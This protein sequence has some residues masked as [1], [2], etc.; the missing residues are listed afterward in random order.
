MPTVVN[1]GASLSIIKAQI[2]TLCNHAEATENYTY[3]IIFTALF[4]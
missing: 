2:A 1:Q 3:I 4:T